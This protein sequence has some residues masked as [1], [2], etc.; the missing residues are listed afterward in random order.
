[1]IFVLIALLSAVIDHVSIF[2]PRFGNQPTFSIPLT[3]EDLVAALDRRCHEE[4]EAQIRETER[5]RQEIKRLHAEL[6]ANGSASDST[7]G[8]QP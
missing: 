5:Q 4:F 7:N 1:L 8:N 2:F 3:T 6:N